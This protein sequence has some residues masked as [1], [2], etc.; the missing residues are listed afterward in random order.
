M[1][2]VAAAFCI[3]FLPSVGAT[4][5]Q[6]AQQRL[7]PTDIDTRTH[8]GAGAGSSGV[9][10]IQTVVLKG[11]PSKAGLYTILLRV[12]A[13]TT[14]QAHEHPDDRV[15]TVISGTWNFGYGARF[16]DSV[17]KALPPGS[18]YTEPPNQP[19]FARTGETAVEVQITGF[20]PTATHYE[21]SADDPASKH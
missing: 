16:D 5:D 10:G 1:K 13:R 4:Q 7:T 12:P 2:I 14:I 20:G 9:I 21:N 18:F 17:L 8:T 19:H 6:S 11:D 15:A 3:L